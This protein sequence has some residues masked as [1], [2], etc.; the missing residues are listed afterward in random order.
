MSKY[1]KAASEWTRPPAGSPRVFLSFHGSEQDQAY[2]AKARLE[3]AGVQV[4]HY[5][6]EKL[7]PDGP[8]EML[9]RIVTECHC[10]VA[11]NIASAPSRFVNFEKAV[12]TEFNIQLLRASSISKVER[13]I[14]R[15][16]EIAQQPPQMLWPARVSSGISRALQQLDAMDFA[17]SDVV[18]AGTTGLD[19]GVDRLTDHQLRR[20]GGAIREGTQSLA[21]ILCGTA[22]LALALTVLAP[23]L[24][25]F[26]AVVIVIA[27]ATAL[28]LR[29]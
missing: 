11:L 14:P 6:P 25:P 16:R 4:L 20:I 9:G 12:S 27:G 26:C 1:F 2:A 22:V 3:A 21:R 13:M 15:I 17:T 19:I 28:W 24:W 8:M 5:D 23:T 10:L 29:S 18:Q 7:W